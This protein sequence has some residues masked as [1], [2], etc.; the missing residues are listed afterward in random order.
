MELISFEENFNDNS[1]SWWIGK[2][3]NGWCDIIEGSYVMEHTKNESDYSVWRTLP[4]IESKA[5]SLEAS[6]TFLSGNRESGFGFL[7]GQKSNNGVDN[8][9]A[10]FHYFVISATGKF[11][12]CSYDPK[13]KK[14]EPIKDWTD[15]PVIKTVENATNIL[16]IVKFD[17][18]IDKQLFFLI[19]DKIVC[20]TNN[21]P[22]FGEETR[23]IAFQN[24]KIAIDNF[25]AIYY[26]D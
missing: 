19:N 1:N 15:S 10:G 22:L 5:Y 11:V 20:Q 13:T 7:W 9:Y 12:I 23:F 3:D 6:F 26:F 21:L 2:D 25:R 4:I 14:A 17:D 18:S 16:K 8:G 24:I